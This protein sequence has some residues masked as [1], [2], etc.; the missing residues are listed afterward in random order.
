MT[1]TA[2]PILI[3]EKIGSFLIVRMIQIERIDCQPPIRVRAAAGKK[4]IDLVLCNEHFMLMPGETIPCAKGHS[5]FCKGSEHCQHTVRTVI[6]KPHHRVI[7]FISCRQPFQTLDQIIYILR[8]GQ[9]L[10]D[11]VSFFRIPAR[12]QFRIFKDEFRNT[13]SH[14]AFHIGKRLGMFR[15]CISARSIQ[16]YLRC[17]FALA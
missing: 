2:D 13:F 14:V 10:R 1:L 6:L 5:L 17:V 4:S 9:I 7:F 11:P 8:T 16:Y 15:E 12:E 3:L